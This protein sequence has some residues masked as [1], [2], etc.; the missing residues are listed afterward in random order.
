MMAMETGKNGGTQCPHD[1]YKRNG[2][3]QC[4]SSDYRLMMEQS[5][6]VHPWSNEKGH[7]GRSEKRAIF[8]VRESESGRYC[9]R[10]I[11]RKNSLSKKGRI[12]F[13][14]GDQ[15]GMIS[16]AATLRYWFRRYCTGNSE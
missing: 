12:L 14:R 4:F 8:C 11:C 5:A 10:E 15:S 3:E 7:R 9:P 13:F 1:S 16:F 2:K 6:K